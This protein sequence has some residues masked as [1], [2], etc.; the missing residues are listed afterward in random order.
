[1]SR[2]WRLPRVLTVSLKRFDPSGRVLRTPVRP[3]DALGEALFRRIIARDSP[4]LALLETRAVRRTLEAAQR[5]LE[6]AQRTLEAAS[7]PFGSDPPLY[8]LSGVVC[9]SG[10]REGGHYV[11]FGRRP[12]TDAWHFHDDELAGV[13]TGPGEPFPPG[14]AV[15]RHCYLLTYQMCPT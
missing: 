1:M 14:D 11:A 7:Q 4:A 12:G 3:C 9:H 5:T 10:T 6:A 15:D 13:A 8:R 2:V